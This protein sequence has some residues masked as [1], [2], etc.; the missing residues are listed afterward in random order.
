MNKPSLTTLDKLAEQVARADSFI[1]WAR[2]CFEGATNPDAA[3]G[4]RCLEEAEQAATNAMQT[5]ATLGAARPG[6]AIARDAVPLE[7]LDTP[8]TRRLLALLAQV[9]EA[10][11]EVDR[12]RG[13]VDASGEPIGFGE[14][15]GNEYE[16]LR[17]EVIGPSGLE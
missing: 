17:A 8:A 4:R 11:A 15:F 3:K 9:A 13:W 12:E 2:P 5:L 7:L 14:S 16:R 10:G 1:G 6:P